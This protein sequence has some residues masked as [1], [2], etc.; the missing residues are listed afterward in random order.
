[1]TVMGTPAARAPAPAAIMRAAPSSV[2]ATASPSSPAGHLLFGKCVEGDLGRQ[3]SAATQPIGH[4][5]STVRMCRQRLTERQGC[6]GQQGGVAI[7]Q[8]W[9]CVPPSPTRHMQED[10]ERDAVQRRR[11]GNVVERRVQPDVLAKGREHKAPLIEHT[12]ESA[13]STALVGEEIVATVGALPIGQGVT[14]ILLPGMPSWGLT[15]RPASS[16]VSPGS[17]KTSRI[18]CRR[19]CLADSHHRPSASGGEHCQYI[20]FCSVSTALPALGVRWS[21]SA[22]YA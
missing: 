17:R 18:A 8:W 13:L 12:K 1:M 7:R 2:L 3:V 21:A 10:Q 9:P 20:A 14:E 15:S 4:R 19:S 6:R 22:S 16:V 5:A 11:H